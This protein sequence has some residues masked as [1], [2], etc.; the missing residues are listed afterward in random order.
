LVRHTV[1]AID[2][3]AG[4]GKSTLARRVAGRLGFLYIDTGAMYR[5]AAL[6][7]LRA[8][9]DP[10]DP[11]AVLPLLPGTEIDFTP[12]GKTL[13]NGEDVS[14]AIRAPEASQ[15]ASKI[16]A[17]PAVRRALVRQQ[18]R[19]GSLRPVVMEG[20][21]IGTVV[22]PGAQVKIFLDAELA[23]RVRRRVE[24]LR[25]QGRNPDP[26]EVEREMSERD[27]RDS[28]R[29]DSPLRPAADAVRVDSTSLSPG[30]VEEE[31]LRIYRLKTQSANIQEGKE[32]SS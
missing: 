32:S 22:F 20:R 21:D 1:I 23:E 17:I 11:A 14:A 10:G 27:S 5:A 26:A 13:L 12:E 3:P 8:G 6:Q 16:S 31:I 4:A 29:T 24:D 18:Q 15:A 9:A 30:G 25:G 2:G 19:I 28:S 7:A